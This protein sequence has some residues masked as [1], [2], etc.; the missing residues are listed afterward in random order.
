[1]LR[2]ICF[3]AWS[4]YRLK[5]P[6]MP[7]GGADQIDGFGVLHAELFHGRH[8][9]SLQWFR[10]ERERLESRGRPPPRKQIVIRIER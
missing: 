3:M 4:S 8:W 10:P 1:M 7:I 2:C 6:A 5:S 9:K